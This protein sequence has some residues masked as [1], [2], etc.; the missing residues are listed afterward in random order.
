MHWGDLLL[1]ICLL[2]IA[3][4]NLNNPIYDRYSRHPD[5]RE[6]RWRD[7]SKP[8]RVVRGWISAVCVLAGIMLIRFGLIS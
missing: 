5:R 6:P 2:G 7:A 3:A 4:Y 8:K 1:G